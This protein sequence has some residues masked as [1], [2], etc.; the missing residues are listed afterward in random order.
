MILI[1]DKDESLH[2]VISDGHDYIPEG[3]VSV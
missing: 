1:L 2:R 3:S